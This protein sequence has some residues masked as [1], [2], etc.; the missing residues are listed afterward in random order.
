MSSRK[1]VLV[2]SDFSG[3][4]FAIQDKEKNGSDVIIA[5]KPK[6]EIEEEKE[7]SYLIQGMGLVE[8]MHLDDLM[9]DRKTY[10]DWFFVWDGNHNT[11]EGELLRK[12]GFKVFGGSQFQFDL[13][14]DREFGIEFAQSVGLESPPFH[15]FQTPDEG[16]KF[17]EANEDKAFVVK[18]N[19]AE[20]SALTQP[21]TRTIEPSNA[22]LEARRYLS[23]MDV[24]DYILQERKKGVEVNVEIF[25]S[26]GIPMLAQANLEDKYRHNGD[27][28][29]PTGCAFDLCWTVPLDCDL[30]KKTAGKFLPKLFERKYTG[31]ADANVIIGD[32]EVWFLEFCFRPGYNAHPNFFTTIANST[33]LQTAADL[34]EGKKPTAKHGFGASVTMFTDKERM[35]IPIYV[36]SSLNGNFYLFDGYK[37]DEDGDDEFSMGGFSKEIAVVTAFDY[38]PERALDAAVDNAYKVKI[39]NSDFRTDCSKT[40]YPL[41]LV[42]RYQALCAMKLF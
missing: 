34:I 24:H 41:S 10:Q 20:D 19:N 23:A 15:E 7:H 9:E 21:F 8:S 17:L 12:E 42:R 37:G 14:N 31:F 32:N 28:G 16:I 39:V 18:P 1:F 29:C 22:N 25:F 38:T 27:L 30:V 5:Y 6:G 35:G 33:F 40:D 2:T 36:P 26:N 3:L 13:E 11:D 4:G